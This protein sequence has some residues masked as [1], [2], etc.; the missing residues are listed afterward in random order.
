M[1][2]MTVVFG[3]VLKGELPDFLVL[4]SVSENRNGFGVFF[5]LPNSCKIFE[6]K[7][8]IVCVL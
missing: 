6:L 5:F 4:D 3:N 8:F 7:Y 2:E 1:Q